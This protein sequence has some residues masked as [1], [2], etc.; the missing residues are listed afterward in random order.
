MP[1][2]VSMLRPGTA[3]YAIAGDERAGDV[4]VF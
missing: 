3:A 1:A 4:C 2:Q